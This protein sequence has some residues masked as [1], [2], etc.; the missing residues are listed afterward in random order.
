MDEIDRQRVLDEE[1]LRLLSL[2]YKVS[3]VMAGLYGCFGL[4]YVAMGLVIALS[5]SSSI[6]SDDIAGFAIF[7]IFGLAFLGIGWGI[8][9]LRWV[10]GSR[11][12]QRRSLLFCQIVAGFTC[13]EIPYGTAVGVLTFIVLARPSVKALFA[14]QPED[15]HLT[16]ASS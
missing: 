1:H 9:A 15:V 3:A 14:P 2:L 12:K 5:E 13:L 16:S 11:L 8:A 6:G 7:L 10:A 4:F